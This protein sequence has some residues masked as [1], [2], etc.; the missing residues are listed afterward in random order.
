MEDATDD[1]KAVTVTFEAG[2][3]RVESGPTATFYDDADYGSG[4]RGSCYL[5]P[6][7]HHPRLA[8]RE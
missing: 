4:Q 8:E 2:V 3:F 6:V 7:G 5:F 1:E